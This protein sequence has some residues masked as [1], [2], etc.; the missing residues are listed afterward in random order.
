[1]RRMLMV[2]S[3]VLAAGLALSVN[4]QPAYLFKDIAPGPQTPF[5]SEGVDLRGAHLFIADD[6]VHGRELWRTDA[7]EAGTWLVKDINPAPGKGS[8]IP[9]SPFD[10]GLTAASDY[11][12]F[13]ADD[14]MH[15]PQL[16]RTDGTSAGTVPLTNLSRGY[17]LG[18]GG[19]AIG[20]RVLFP[21]DD[22]IHGIELWGTD[23][24]PEGTALIKNV[25]PGSGG[26]PSSQVVSR[27]LAFFVAGDEELGVTKIF[28]SDG[29]KEGTFGLASAAD[30]TEIVEVSGS[31]FFS[32]VHDWNAALDRELWKTDGTLANT[33]LVKAFPL[34]GEVGNLV[35]AGGKLFFLANDG[36]HGRQLWVSDGTE[37][38]TTMV[39][40]IVSGNGVI[41]T[42]SFCYRYEP[43][44]GLTGTEDGV[45]FFADS[46]GGS[47]VLSPGAGYF[48]NYSLWWS[49]GTEAGTRRLK[50]IGV[51]SFLSGSS[52]INPLLATI[53][54]NGILYFDAA[55][56][57]HGAELW[58]S[59][60]TAEGTVLLQD[61]SPGASS[62]FPWS[63]HSSPTGLYFTASTPG[64]A[65]QLWF[66]PDRET[67]RLGPSP[68][69]RPHGRRQ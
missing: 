68:P 12:T 56:D 61:I 31:V 32:A 21:A 65:N 27:G 44:L 26:L 17:A 62:S 54:R 52:G 67:L 7:T 9:S 6:G 33:Q 48:R 53:V 60:G 59:D 36:I 25:N 15:G 45:F 16:W 1:M 50:E 2:T 55:D 42:C 46:T 18:Y 35:S 63:F 14:G 19:M 41:L 11:A 69:P 22:G 3:L 40:D 43:L 4:A 39:K 20:S 51:P 30:Y 29:S 10:G 13:F 37:V 8:T 66:L 5:S 34:P 23:G 24:T 58:R 28:R 49:D 57:A 47:A 38:G 64:D